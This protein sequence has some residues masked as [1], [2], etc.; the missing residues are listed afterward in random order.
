MIIFS[1]IFFFKF[2]FF[3][4]KKKNCSSGFSA[5]LNQSFS[6]A[7]FDTSGNPFT[8]DVVIVVSIVNASGNGVQINF[9]S[10]SN[11]IYQ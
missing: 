2:F 11:G 5:G 7:V 9:L 4:F 1:Q 8:G 6:V 10:S 3:F